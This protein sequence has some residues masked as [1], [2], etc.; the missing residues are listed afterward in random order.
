[1]LN[2]WIALKAR[3]LAKPSNK[4]TVAVLAGPEGE[5]ALLLNWKAGNLLAFFSP[6]DIALRPVRYG[7]PGLAP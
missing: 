6:I 4:L 2:W 7:L 5:Q 3:P 1:M